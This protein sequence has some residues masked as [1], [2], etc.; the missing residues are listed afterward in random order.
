MVTASSSS[1]VVAPRWLRVTALAERIA[2]SHGTTDVAAWLAV[3]EDALEFDESGHCLACGEIHLARFVP[4]TGVGP[5]RYLELFSLII[6]GTRQKRKDALGYRQQWRPAQRKPMYPA[7]YLE[8]E[9]LIK[10]KFEPI[11]GSIKK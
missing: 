6:Q 8:K 10:S 1:P 5:G 4:F 7:S 2:D 11:F 3:A 9:Q